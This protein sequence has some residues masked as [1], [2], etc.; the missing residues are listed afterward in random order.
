MRQNGGMTMASIAVDANPYVW[1]YDGDIPRDA[2]ALINIDWQVDFAGGGGYVDVMG[3]DL[4]LTRTPLGPARKVL[5][6]AREVGLFVV[7]TRSGD[8]RRPVPRSERRDPA[9]AS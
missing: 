8:R 4:S 3:Y 6:A 7:H 1:S 2:S 9:A 5:Q